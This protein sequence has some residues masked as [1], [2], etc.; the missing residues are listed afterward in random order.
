MFG[1]LVLF[2]FISHSSAYGVCS[3]VVAEVEKFLKRYQNRRIFS[4]KTNLFYIPLDMI[5]PMLCEGHIVFP[6]NNNKSLSSVVSQLLEV[7]TWLLHLS[8]V[9]LSFSFSVAVVLFCNEVH[10]LFCYCFYLEFWTLFPEES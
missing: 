6:L 4:I 9:Y 2:L 7:A 8:F 3:Q 1:L 5:D 10:S